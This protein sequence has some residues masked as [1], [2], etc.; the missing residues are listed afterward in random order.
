ML[1]MQSA[2]A[3]SLG[4]GAGMPAPAM[5]AQDTMGSS[6]KGAD[7]LTSKTNSETVMVVDTN[8]EGMIVSKQDQISYSSL[9]FLQNDT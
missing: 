5:Q 6:G 8:H 4:G 7:L 3:G 1:N 2:N 9:Y